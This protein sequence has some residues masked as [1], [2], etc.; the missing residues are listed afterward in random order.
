MRGISTQRIERRLKRCF[1]AIVS[2]GFGS[3]IDRVGRRHR[4]YLNQRAT[5]DQ[6]QRGDQERSNQ[7]CSALVFPHLRIMC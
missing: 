3:R 1:G 2:L 6:K 5:C 4:R 7:G